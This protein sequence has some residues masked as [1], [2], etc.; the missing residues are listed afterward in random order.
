MKPE[1]ESIGKKILI[2][3]F[4]R[5]EMRQYTENLRAV[6]EAGEKKRRDITRVGTDA[7]KQH[8]EIYDIEWMKLQNWKKRSEKK[9][10]D[11]YKKK[12][13]EYRKLRK[14]R[15]GEIESMMMDGIM[16]IDRQVEHQINAFDELYKKRLEIIERAKECLAKGED[17]KISKNSDG[18]ISLEVPPEKDQNSLVP[19]A[20]P[21]PA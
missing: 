20:I 7:A 2:G 10:M 18:T 9:L 4:E 16:E 6:K 1:N 5:L 17:V 14:G 13:L 11:L 12:E 19:E 21:S 8:G 15:Y 3:E